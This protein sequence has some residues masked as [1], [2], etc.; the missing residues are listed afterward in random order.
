[1][2]VCLL[3]PCLGLASRDLRGTK[4]KKKRKG[5]GHIQATRGHCHPFKLTFSHLLAVL[6]SACSVASL[7]L[8]STFACQGGTEYSAPTLQSAS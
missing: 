6:S 4:D 8:A 3:L 5:V 2:E 1:M 7:S